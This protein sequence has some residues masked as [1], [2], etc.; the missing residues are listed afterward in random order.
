MGDATAGRQALLVMDMQPAVLA[1]VADAEVLLSR[2]RGAIAAARAAGLPVLHVVV[3]ESREPA[4]P[5][6]SAA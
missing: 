1:H 3:H 4:A 5:V 2:T 6:L